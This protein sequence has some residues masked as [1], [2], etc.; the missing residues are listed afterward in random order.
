MV[1]STTIGKRLYSLALNMCVLNFSIILSCI[2]DSEI[3]WQAKE[4][5]DDAYYVYYLDP[6]SYVLNF[7]RIVSL[8]CVVG[9]MRLT[10]QWYEITTRK[11]K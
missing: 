1:E 10:Y 9:T 3:R 4:E 2:I 5:F 8:V 6:K 7:F 11:L